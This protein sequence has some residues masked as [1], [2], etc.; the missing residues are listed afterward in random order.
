MWLKNSSISMRQKE[1]LSSMKW[2]LLMQNQCWMPQKPAI[3]ADTSITF[4]EQLTGTHY[5]SL[6]LL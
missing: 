3:A 1:N 6:W 4:G 2:L 5:N